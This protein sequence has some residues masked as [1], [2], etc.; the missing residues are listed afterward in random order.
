MAASPIELHIE[1]P[2]LLSKRRRLTDALITGLMWALYSYLWAPLVS[3]VAWLLGAE[4][5][6]DVMV[7]AG[8]I[9]ALKD[10][11]WFYLVMLLCIFVV[12]TAWSLVNRLRFAGKDRRKA[13]R[14]V[15]SAELAAYYSLDTEQWANLREAR[16]V[17]MSVDEAGV[18]ENIVPLAM[19]RQKQSVEATWE[20]GSVA[21]EEAGYDD[22]ISK[23]VG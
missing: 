17:R 10:V 19:R 2:E 5:A 1:A 16:V 23:F 8:G 13:R 3:L 12:V 20:E 15:T 7:R 18:I 6:Y 4:F 9:H 21:Q 11:M 22:T 14:V